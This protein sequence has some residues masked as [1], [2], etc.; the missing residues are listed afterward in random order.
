M[1]FLWL[2]ACSLFDNIYGKNMHGYILIVAATEH[3]QTRIDRP[4]HTP[5][6]FLFPIPTVK[7]PEMIL[8]AL[9]NAVVFHSG[10]LL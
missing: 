9:Y 7:Q 6:R 3:T 2:L 1:V 4:H 5:I 8:S 10:K